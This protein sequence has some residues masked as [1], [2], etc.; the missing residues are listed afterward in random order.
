MSTSTPTSARDD[1]GPQGQTTQELYEAALEANQKNSTEPSYPGYGAAHGVL[2]A[3][4][5]DAQ[6]AHEL[7][8][9]PRTVARW[10][11][12]REGPPVTRVGRR[13]MYRRSAVEAWLADL[14]RS[15]VA[16]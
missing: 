16:S 15:Q 9:S 1:D 12:M 3:Y 6:L 14:E 10:R 7:N 2:E 11:A 13:V 8:V 5:D 4:L